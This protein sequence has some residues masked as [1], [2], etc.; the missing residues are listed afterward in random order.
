[1][2]FHFVGSVDEG[3]LE[4]VEDWGGYCFMMEKVVLWVR[5]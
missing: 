5:E 1:M 4:G 2:S 3:F